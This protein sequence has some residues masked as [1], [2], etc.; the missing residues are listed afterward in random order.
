M[1]EDYPA[2]KES[3]FGVESP[4]T[5]FCLGGKRFLIVEA[6]TTD[7]EVLKQHASH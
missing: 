3:Y 5:G 2:N 6:D 7:D 1:N 4:S